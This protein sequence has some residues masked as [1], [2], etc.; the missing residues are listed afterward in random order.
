MCKKLQVYKVNI[1]ILSLGE[2]ILKY[3]KMKVV[4]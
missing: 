1:P 3:N 4:I 2:N